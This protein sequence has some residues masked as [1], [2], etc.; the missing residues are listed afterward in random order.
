MPFSPLPLGQ[1]IPAKLHGVS[2]SLPT[3]RAVIGYEEKD[4]AIVQHLSSGYPRF[5]QHPILK[6]AGAYLL[7]HR[8]LEDHYLWLTSSLR[9]AEALRQWLAPEVATVVSHQGLHG[10]AV[11]LEG[12]GVS[13]AKTWLQHTGALASSRAAEDFLVRVGEQPAAEPEETYSGDSRKRILTYLSEAY[14]PATEDDLFLANSGMNAIWAAY[15][16]VSALQ[17]PR[18]R[19]VWVQL[20]WLYLDTIAILQKFSGGAENY[21]LHSNVFDLEGLKRLF[22]ARGH[23][24]AGVITE[25]PTNPLLQT[26]DLA[27]VYELCRAAGALLVV[28]PTVVSPLNINVLPHADLVVNSLTKYTA[29]EGDVL[30]GAVVLRPGCDDAVYLR[31]QL[32]R[33]LEPIYSRDLM[34][35]AAQISDTAAVVQK[36]NETAAR[37]VTFL[38]S[39]PRIASLYWSLRA[40]SA[41]NY[42]RLARGRDRIGSMVS[43]T[44]K[45]PLS[46]FYDRLRLPKGPSFGMKTSLLCP[47]I[48]LAHY[49]LVT[50]VE[51]QKI[52]AANDLSPELL[53]LSVGCEPAED[54]IAAL[55]EALD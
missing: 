39:H 55:A 7:K 9:S 4:P 1:R 36:T 23:E 50:S 11:P 35:L 13:R 20:G 8:G 34:R 10:V 43:F 14:A 48:Y 22:A 32:A 2:C 26:P 49:D 40:E 21:V 42:E 30:F 27:A 15:R 3:M 31:A 51:G 41:E 5:V 37:V 33:E 19:R 28:D 6:R 45:G 18:G 29:S 12:N 25:V 16:A 47:F 52:L 17:A 46:A 24:I 44:V 53:R 38:E 54:I